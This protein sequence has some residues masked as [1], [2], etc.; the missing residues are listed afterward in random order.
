MFPNLQIRFWSLVKN[1]FL[2]IFDCN[3][4]LSRLPLTVLSP[5]VLHGFKLEGASPLF[6]IMTFPR[7]RL[8][9]LFCF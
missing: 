1:E 5:G 7:F 6:V 4:L 3:K 2:Y 8:F 9:V